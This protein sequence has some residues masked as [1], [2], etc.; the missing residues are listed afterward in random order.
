MGLI[1]I[2]LMDNDAELL[3]MCLLV[4]C[5]YIPSLV[6][7]YFVS[8]AH[9]P[10]GLFFFLSFQSSLC[11]VYINLLSNIL[12]A[13]FSQS[14]TCLLILLTRLLQSK[15]FNLDEV[16]LSVFHFIYCVIG[17]NI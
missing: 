8:F 6:K 14:I 12:F 15:S 16:L 13:H 5:I 10:I 4:T 7:C 9:F 1:C 11:I 2:S 17:V 3:F